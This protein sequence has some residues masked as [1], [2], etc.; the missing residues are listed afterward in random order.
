MINHFD[1]WLETH[2]SKRKDLELKYEANSAD[3]PFPS[4]NVI[5]I[6]RVTAIIL[7]NCSNKHLY[8]SYE[9]RRA[10]L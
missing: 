8:N 4:R 7:E 9:V 2:I 5:Q 3:G 10:R 6:L 1:A